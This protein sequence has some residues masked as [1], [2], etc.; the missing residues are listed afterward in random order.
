MGRDARINR[1]SRGLPEGSFILDR[2]NRPITAGCEM[3]FMQPTTASIYVQAIEPA[4]QMDPRQQPF[5]PGMVR[6]TGVAHFT[7]LAPKGVPQR[8]FLLAR[9][10]EELIAAGVI[11][12]V[13]AGEVPQDGEGIA[14]PQADRRAAEP[15]TR[16]ERTAAD[17]GPRLVVTD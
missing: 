3:T 1:E 15:E 16:P 2:Y 9:T 12:E 7:F 11:Q 6:I 13:A 5:P 8:E 10:V 17:T 14:V 4:V